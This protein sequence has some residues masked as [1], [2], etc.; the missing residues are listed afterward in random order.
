MRI[1]KYLR[2]C[3]I[4]SRRKAEE[5]VKS[6]RVSVNG[7]KT[8]DYVDVSDDD[9][10]TV[11]GKRI[12][13]KTKM[14]YMFNKPKDYITTKSD[15]QG[16]KTIFDLLKVS[17]DIFPVGRLDFDTEGLL[18]LTNDGDIANK[19]LHPKYE[20]PRIYQAVVALC[21]NR[22]EVAELKRG[23]SLPYGYTAKMEVKILSFDGQS[24]KIEINIKEGRKR[25]I[26]RALKFLGHPVISLKRI[27]F[28][29]VKIDENLKSGEFRPL[30]DEEI[31]EL[32]EY[33]N[34][35]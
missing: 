19:L 35:E 26:R 16:R 9:E 15:P 11:D 27:S 17:S 34:I 30:R 33:V 22:D 1:Q 23:I 25:E 8:L 5:F 29:P 7:L 2:N 31:H 6:G 24:T 18:I 4:A 3:G 21:M 20:V 14:Y 10:I 28:G 13:V 12:D 32:I